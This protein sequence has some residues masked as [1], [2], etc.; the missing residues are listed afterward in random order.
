MEKKKELGTLLFSTF[1]Q[2][3]KKCLDGRDYSSQWVE[4]LNPRSMV[5]E[6]ENPLKPPLDPIY[7][8]DTEI[9]QQNC[10]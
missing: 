2:Q 7:T 8:V 3:K 9:S 5:I 10:S 6:V 4:L 1:I